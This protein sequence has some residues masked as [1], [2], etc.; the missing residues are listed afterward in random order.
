MTLD[1]HHQTRW[2]CKLRAGAFPKVL[3]KLLREREHYQSLLKQEFVKIKEQQDPEL[4]K[5]YEARQIAA[6]LLANA[7]YGVFAR[8][9]F[10][11]RL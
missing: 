6:K 3:R 9:E 1:F 5:Y 8:K 7:G 4:I 11:F 2:I 10:V